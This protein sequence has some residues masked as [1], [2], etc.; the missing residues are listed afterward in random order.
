MIVST[1]S[2]VRLA[3]ATDDERSHRTKCPRI[4]PDTA[5]PGLGRPEPATRSARIGW[6]RWPRHSRR[7]I[8]RGTVRINNGHRGVIQQLVMLR[9]VTE[10][11]MVLRP[12]V[13]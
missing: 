4:A 3:F 5:P 13:A 2:P 11:V 10:D 8:R 7:A 6:L 12:E 1:D 9:F